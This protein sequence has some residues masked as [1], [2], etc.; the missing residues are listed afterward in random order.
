MAL[1]AAASEG[2]W[3][4]QLLSEISVHLSP[5]FIL[6]EDNTSAIALASHGRL[7]SRCKHIDIKYHSIQ[8]YIERG[9]L[10][11]LYTPTSTMCADVLTKNL[12]VHSHQLH[13]KTLMG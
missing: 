7:T 11:V 5:T 3:L 9:I 12:G 4:M 6:F 1:S 8:E 10:T 13:S 2:R